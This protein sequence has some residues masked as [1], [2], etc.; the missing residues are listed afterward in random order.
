[1]RRKTRVTSTGRVLLAAL[2]A[3]HHWVVVGQWAI[4][5]VM[6]V[7]LVRGHG[8]RF[9]T[10][11]AVPGSD[12]ARALD[13]VSRALGGTE[14]PDTDTVVLHARHGTV[15]DPLVRA[16][17]TALVAQL[18][19]VPRV[20]G[21]VD[22][23]S[24]AG[25]V[26]LGVDP[27]SANRHTA[28]ASVIV[29][30]SAL[31][32]DRATAQR[33]VSTAR[34]YDGPSLQVEVA[35]P[36]AAAVNATA[37]SPWPILGALLAALL[38]LA[39]T[40]R[41]RGA[42]VV[43]AVTTAVATATALAVVALLSHVTTMTLYAPLLA[44]VV[45]AGTSLGGT[46]VVVHRAQSGLREGAAPLEAVTR[47]AAQTGFAIACGGLCVT[48]AMDAVVALGLPFFSGVALGSAAAGT[49]TGLVILTL[50]PALLAICGPRLLGWTE[51]Q[52]LTTSGRGL[53]HP[54]GLRARWAGLVHRR[55][56]VAACAAGLLLVVLAAPAVTLKLGGADDGAE[57]TSSST[58]R[59]YD[60]LSADF[61][62]GLNGPMI[63]AVELGPA[64]TAVSPD[65][66]VATLGRTPGVERA[67]VN[68][69]NAKAGVAMIRVFPAVGPRSPAATA[70]LS[71]LREQV[72]PRA[73]AGTGS[74]AYVGGS[75]ALFADM[76]ASFQGATTGFLAIVLLAL[77]G[78]AYLMLRSA[79]LAAA[80]ALASALSILA[81]AGV[82]A[83]LFQTS[84]VTRALGLATGPVE[85]SLLVIV[86]VAVFGLLPGLNFSLLVRLLEPAGPR[87]SKGRARGRRGATGP[88][89]L[90]HADVG[91]VMLTMNLVMLFLFAAVAAQPARMMKVVGC[92]LA[93]GVAID[94]FLLRATLLPAL[95]HL[96]D[97]RSAP[98]AAGERVGTPDRRRSVAEL[99]WTQSL[100]GGAPTPATAVHDGVERVTVPIRIS[101]TE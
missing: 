5:L 98:A 48:L 28:V 56:L 54:P 18:G 60:L 34:S 10:D 42:V 49:A 12:S 1:M 77:L 50:L 87:D 59:A 20:A 45:A 96:L 35:G 72:I 76:A 73:L 81:A 7:V 41:S 82:L 92:G 39:A 71:R 99:D 21:V 89:R 26:V 14:I 70:L 83:L 75:T 23:F 74:R 19:K 91:H 51:R 86:L 55:P 90:G 44:A 84:L 22:P 80:L 2:C 33:L 8:A 95:L 52:H 101:R 31:H 63:V 36:D 94:A 47:A 69:N 100:V 17:I 67:A 13:L 68:V 62:P 64:A 97:R 16:Q 4:C 37:I 53:S 66:L 58:R 29:K 88:V 24:P 65:A 46:V 93:A 9:N 6:L 32:P 15:D 61:F 25:A 40:L 11:V 57:S 85:P 78:C 38:L 30:G 43:C 79:T 27:V 3:R